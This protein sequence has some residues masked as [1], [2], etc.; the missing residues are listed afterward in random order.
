MPGHAE[1][2]HDHAFRE[3]ASPT[4]AP[5]SH[6]LET[7][8]SPSLTAAW[9]KL[10]ALKDVIAF[11]EGL[12]GVPSFAALLERGRQAPVPSLSPAEGLPA[13]IIYTSGPPA[14]RR[15]SFCVSNV[16]ALNEVFPFEPDDRSL[17]FLRWAHAFGQAELNVLMSMGCS[18]TLN[19]D[20]KELVDDLAEVKPTILVAVPRI[21]NRLYRAVQEQ[22]HGQ[23]RFVRALYAAAMRAAVKRFVGNGEARLGLLD[24]LALRLADRLVFSKVRER[25]GDRLKYAISGSAALG[26][27]VAQFMEAVGIR[28]YEGYGFTEHVLVRRQSVV[29][30]RPRTPN[31]WRRLRSSSGPSRPTSSRS[32]PTRTEGDT[33][34][35]LAHPTEYVGIQPPGVDKSIRSGSRDARPES[36]RRSPR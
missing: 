32:K 10:P 12:S 7:R 22:W 24:S 17:S 33:A 28:I 9:P 25:F 27:D 26:T 36:N 23:P 11:D 29:S 8:R 34:R 4:A 30:R 2:R 20:V 35:S 5:R 15:A 21:F 1:V 18:L 19:R 13:A 14:C 31:E 16:N 6:S 3:P